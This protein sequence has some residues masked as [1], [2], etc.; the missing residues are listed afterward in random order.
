MLR[1]QNKASEWSDMSTCWICFSELAMCGVVYI[2]EFR[3]KYLNVNVLRGTTDDGR[4]GD[5]LWQLGYTNN[6]FFINIFLLK[7][8]SLL[9]L[10]KCQICF[11]AVHDT[12]YQ[13]ILNDNG[14]KTLILKDNGK[15]LINWST[16]DNTIT[17]IRQEEKQWIT[18]NNNTGS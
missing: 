7:S 3:G 5:K 14:K 18:K 4:T 1:N 9:N 15:N 13:L 8:I 10:I 6:D 2:S 17:K 12:L 16:L 11:K